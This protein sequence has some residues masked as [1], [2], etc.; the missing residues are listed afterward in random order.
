MAQCPKC[1]LTADPAMKFCTGCGN[2]I[3]EEAAPSMARCSKCGS[4]NPRGSKFCAACGAPLTQA[5]MDSPQEKSAAPPPC[6]ACGAVSPEGS[7]FCIRC[8][9]AIGAGSY[10]PPP[11]PNN[12]TGPG[13]TAMPLLAPPPLTTELQ[14]VRMILFFGVG[15]NLV[16]IFQLYRLMSGLQQLW[17]MYANTGGLAFGM[18]VNVVVA[19]CLAFSAVQLGRG[20]LKYGKIGAVVMTVTGVLGIVLGGTAD[21]F[22]F[23]LNLLYLAGGIWAWVL[24]RQAERNTSL[25]V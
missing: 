19:A 2:P 13:T 5:G 18:F 16:G 9:K 7:R 25:T 23:I 10:S 6:A 24:V 3:V 8:G 12:A 20:D 22:T 14:R 17:G 4:E 21:G 1:G 11:P 15:V